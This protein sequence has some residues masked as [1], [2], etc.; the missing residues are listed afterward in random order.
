MPRWSRRRRPRSCGVEHPG[1]VVEAHA[2]S[3]V[4]EKQTASGDQIEVPVA[5]EICQCQGS[6]VRISGPGRDCLAVGL[7]RAVAVAEVNSDEAGG[8]D[9]EIEVF[10]V[11]EPVL[12]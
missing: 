8:G 4:R 11:V 9:D 5:I 10:I 12:Q 2:A 1:T 7:E 6:D 3:A